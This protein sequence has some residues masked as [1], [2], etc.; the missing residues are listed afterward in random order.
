MP[1]RT[2][3][4]TRVVYV[5]TDKE[6]DP[7]RLH[8]GNREK[9]A[10]IALSYCWGG[11]Q[12][13]QTERNRIERYMHTL[14]VEELPKSLQD[15]ILLTR[16]LGFQYIWIDSLCIIQDCDEDK[17]REITKMANIYKNAVLTISAATAESC[18][19][20]FLGVQEKRV[21]LLQQNAIKL[22]INCLNGAIGSVL[23]YP[24]RSLFRNTDELVAIE[25]RA[26]TYQEQLLS[27]R[28]V[29]FFEDA[30]EW[31]CYSC[32]LSDDRL[33]NDELGA[34]DPAY[35][36]LTKPSYERSYGMGQLLRVLPRHERKS[37][38]ELETLSLFWQRA[39]FEYTLGSLSNLDDRLPAIAGIAS[40]FYK[41]TGDVYIAGLWKSCLIRDLQ[42]RTRRQ[43]YESSNNTGRNDF[44][45]DAPTW[46]WASVHDCVIIF[47]SAQHDIDSDRVE[48]IDCKVNRVS[49]SAPF[50]SVNGG[51]LKIRAPIKFVS[52]REVEEVLNPTHLDD[53]KLDELLR[54]K[55]SSAMFIGGIFYDMRSRRHGD[56]PTTLRGGAALPIKSTGIWCL[57]LSRH[58]DLNYESSGLALAKR[59][60]G[61][62]ERIGL[63]QIYVGDNWHDYGAVEQHEL[64]TSWGDD[65]VVTTVTIV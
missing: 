50:G 18:D 25:K 23:L 35:L 39:V 4:P 62:F 48:I 16:A 60:D 40:E 30:M 21:Q 6:H 55:Q 54:L 36:E 1:I 44:K 47:S 59:A 17:D 63:F 52:D 14:P 27:R 9:A 37:P 5:G 11:P 2:E 3:L 22:P 34:T 65:Y 49:A 31:S 57:G 51:E 29:S 13:H 26:W 33:G 61:L 28:V 8:L 45:Y 10:Y 7:P 46:T 43:L 24:S 42:W 53:E 64:R 58:A 32:H 12:R 56:E 19:D 15:A 20:G 38:K 41:M